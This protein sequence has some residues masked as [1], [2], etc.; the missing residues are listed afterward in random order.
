M[1]PRRK[2][3]GRYARHVGHAMLY[4]LCAVLAAEFAFLSGAYALAE[5]SKNVHRDGKTWFCH[6]SSWIDVPTARSLARGTQQLGWGMGHRSCMRSNG[7]MSRA[8]F[9]LLLETASQ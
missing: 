8:R 4:A 3:E 5:S 1:R 9:G 2:V 6:T 7:L